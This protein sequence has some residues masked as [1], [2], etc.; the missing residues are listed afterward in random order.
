MSSELLDYITTIHHPSKPKIMLLP[1]LPLVVLP[2]P[3]LFSSLELKVNPSDFLALMLL[4][5]S[6]T[7]TLGSS[8]T[9]QETTLTPGLNTKSLTN[10][11]ILMMSLLANTNTLMIPWNLSELVTNLEL[12]V[13]TTPV[14]TTTAM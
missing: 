2:P 13:T 1:I 10:L 3:L 4:I 9:T 7:A 6:G 14:L 11:P 5:Q 8:L 12:P